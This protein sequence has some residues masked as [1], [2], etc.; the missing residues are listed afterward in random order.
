MSNRA[1]GGGGGGTGIIYANGTNTQIIPEDLTEREP[2]RFLMDIAAIENQILPE[3]DNL[4]LNSDGRFFRVLGTSPTDET[5]IIVKLLAVSGSGSGGG[6]GGSSVER[7]V[8]ISWDANTIATGRTYIYGQDF[9]AVF[10]P[11]TTAE[12]DTQCNITFNIIDIEHGTTTVITKTNQTSGVPFN[13]NMNQLP[14]SGN[15]T[16]K[17]IVTSDNSMYN[18]GLGYERNIT[19]L[20]VVSMGI[21]KVSDKYIPLIDWETTGGG[22]ELQYIPIGDRNITETLHIYVDEE[23]IRTSTVDPSWYNRDVTITIPRQSHG[24]H[25][26]ELKISTDINGE[27]IYT[28]PITFEAA[29]TEKDIDDPVIWVG[30]YDSLVVNYENSYIDYMVYD[31]ISIKQGLSAPVQLYKNGIVISELSLEYSTTN[32]LSWDISSIYEVGRNLFSIVCRGARKDVIV[33]VTEEGSRDLSLAKKDS[34][35]ENFTAAGRSSLEVKSSRGVWKDLVN[36]EP[37]TLINF[38]WQNNGWK[39]DTVIGDAVDSGT[40]LSVANGAQLSFPMPSLRLNFDRDYT[41]EARF[42]IRN[43]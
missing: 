31:P 25:I 40:Y 14:E 41:I 42:R 2:V 34:L 10:T 36:N 43:V 21:K 18:Y 30:K 15:I 24:T 38:N 28:E 19:N 5:K 37:A 11:T 26:I 39:K 1:G 33:D 4:I 22:L 27:T 9:N 16:L 3:I 17:I 7:D 12:G 32:W 23:E 35:L 29:W 8:N 6:G 13:F 20:R